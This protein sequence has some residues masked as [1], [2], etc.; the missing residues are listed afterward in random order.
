MRQPTSE[1]FVRNAA[2]GGMFPEC[3]L[4]GIQAASDGEPITKNPYMT[5]GDKWQRDRG[6]C[7]SSGWWKGIKTRK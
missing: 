5:E 4:E 2:S 1:D 3:Y 6:Y 7:W